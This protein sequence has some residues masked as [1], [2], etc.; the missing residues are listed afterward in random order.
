MYAFSII[1][2]VSWLQRANDTMY[3]VDR[4]SPTFRL[5]VV[6]AKFAD[7]ANVTYPGTYEYFLQLFDLIN[8]DLGYAL[9]AG[10]I[11]KDLDFHDRWLITVLVPFGVIALLAVTWWRSRR[12]ATAMSEDALEIVYNKHFSA[13]LLLAF[14]VYSSVTSTLFQTLACDILDDGTEYLRADYQIQCTSPRHRV[15]HSLSIFMLSIFTTGI[16]TAF[17]FLL[18]QC[19]DVLEDENV[20]S[21]DAGRE[22]DQSEPNENWV[23]AQRI[24]DLWD[25][26]TPGC[27]YYEVGAGAMTLRRR[28]KTSFGLRMARGY[29]IV[30]HAVCI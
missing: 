14:L 5:C 17:L 7:V 25:A 6:R 11:V 20:R 15:F 23:R 16:P 13:A 24:K 22:D 21:S 27:W 4:H 2:V 18:W 12:R 29:Q 3:A 28:F 19:R 30:S 1:A 9:S 26:Y 10:C 8:L